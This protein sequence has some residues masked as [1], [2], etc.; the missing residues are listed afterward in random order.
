MGLSAPLLGAVAAG[1][2]TALGGRSI[3]VSVT[4][5]LTSEAGRLAVASGGGR[6]AG[7]PAGPIASTIAAAVARRLEISY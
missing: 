2:P 3:A 1:T 6:I 4:V 5:E 7:Y